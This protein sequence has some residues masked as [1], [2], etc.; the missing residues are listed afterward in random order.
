MDRFA[1]QFTLTA[2]DEASTDDRAECARHHLA[3]F[4]WDIGVLERDMGLIVPLARAGR[5]RMADLAIISPIY[6]G[7]AALLEWRERYPEFAR[8]WDGLAARYHRLLETYTE[9]AA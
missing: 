9:L 6:W 4:R 1:A 7:G 2:W 8:H 3:E 5:V